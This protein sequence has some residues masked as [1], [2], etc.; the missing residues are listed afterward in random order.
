MLG[1][2]AAPIAFSPGGNLSAMRAGEVRVAFEATYVPKPSKSITSPEQ[3][4]TSNKT[5]N[6]QLSPVFPRPRLAIGIFDGLSIEATY[7]PPVTVMDATPNLFSVALAY[8]KPLGSGGL[9]VAARAHGTLGSVKGPITCSPDVIQTSDPS[10]ICYATEPSEDTYKPKM[11]GVE[12]AL[13]FGGGSRYSGYVGTGFTWLKPR[14]H[15]G[16]VDAA[17]VVD[18]TV[19][20]V[21]LERIAAFAGGR[22]DYTDAI[23]FT[24]E[25]YSVPK[26]VTTFRVGASYRLR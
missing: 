21:D 6:T 9:S 17:G 25:V 23:G 26:D 10:G 7:L 22:W 1:F 3:C 20:I 4:Y 19:V 2:F 14:F 11:Y 15:V 18:N 24:A 12:G 13:G 5:E 16:Y 8:V